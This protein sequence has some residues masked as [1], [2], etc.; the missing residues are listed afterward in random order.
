MWPPLSRPRSVFS[1]GCK[2]ENHYCARVI[3]RSALIAASECQ[4]GNSCMR[5]PHS[6]AQ[7]YCIRA[8]PFHIPPRPLRLVSLQN[9]RGSYRVDVGP[10]SFRLTCLAVYTRNCIGRA[11]WIVFRGAGLLLSYTV[12][13]IRYPASMLV[14]WPRIRA[15]N[16]S[17]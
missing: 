6:W 9:S 5:H 16:V 2:S 1:E 12:V 14:I 13:C 10:P 15:G 3:N 8:Y 17:S 4:S 7:L 11:E